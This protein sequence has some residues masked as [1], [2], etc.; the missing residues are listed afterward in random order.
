MRF[1]KE[2]RR[3]ERPRRLKRNYPC[4][5]VRDDA[6]PS[7]NFQNHVP[8]FPMVRIYSLLLRAHVF[9]M[10]KFHLCQR[11]VR[12]AGNEAVE[13]EQTGLPLEQWDRVLVLL[14]RSGMG[15]GIT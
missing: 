9:I 11:K 5:R 7:F 4:G 14:P 13:L 15:P 8:A 10:C 3:C 6:R 1:C 2:E 12:T